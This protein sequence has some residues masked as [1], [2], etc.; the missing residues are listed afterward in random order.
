MAEVAE[1]QK[2]LSDVRNEMEKVQLNNKKLAEQNLEH[3]KELAGFKNMYTDLVNQL[4]KNDGNIAEK[5]QTSMDT[6]TIE[7]IR[8]EGLKALNSITALENKWSWAEN[9]INEQRGHIHNLYCR[10][11]AIE[12][13]SRIN[14]LLFHGLSLPE[15]TFG[16]SLNKHIVDSI[17]A[18]LPDLEIPL[19][20][21]D[22]DIAHTLK[23]KRSGSKPVTIVK[24]VRRTVRNR[25]FFAKSQL[26]KNNS[27]F[28]ITEHLTAG[29]I[30]LLS[31]VKDVVGREN[32]WTSQTKVFANIGKDKNTGKDKKIQ[33]RD[34]SDLEKLR[35]MFAYAPPMHPM[36][37]G[38]GH[39]TQQPPPGYNKSVH[40]NKS[41]HNGGYSPTHYEIQNQL[42]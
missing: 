15:K 1:L 16:D 7:R 29:T 22:I 11:N 33:I 30:S 18:A 6:A 27:S 34:L 39:G 17:N 40:P 12:Q 38:V 31:D 26:K 25:I 37:S 41:S 42:G 2:M 5:C 28:T 36:Q 23:T 20:T 35:S 9:N 3:Q 21:Q 4:P 13:Y 14:S 19:Q 32:A 10:L 24:F 8:L